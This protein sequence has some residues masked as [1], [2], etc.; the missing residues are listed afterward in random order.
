MSRVNVYL[1]FEGNCREAMNFY[2]DC[3]GG[4]LALQELEGSPAAEQMPAEKRQGILHAHLESGGIVIMGSDM[5][6][7]EGIINGNACSMMVECDTEEQ[8]RGFYSKLSDGATET[9]EPAD[10]FWGSIFAHLKDKYGK[11]WSMN[12]DKSKSA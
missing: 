1:N 4:D 2:K 3:F 9:Y 8:L 6:G 12:Y 7:P 11:I 10:S 5:S